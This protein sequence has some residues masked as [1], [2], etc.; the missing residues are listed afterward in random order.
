MTIFILL[1]LVLL[2]YMSVWYFIALFFKRNDVADIAW[3]LGFVLLA[4]ASYYFSYFSIRA[5]I[6]NVLVTIWGGRLAWHIFNRNR[7][8]PEDSRYQAWRES[9]KLFYIRSFLQI[10]LLQGIILFVISYPVMFINL[11]M[12]KA[13]QLTDYLGIAVWLIGFFFESV[14]DRQLKNF[15]SKPENKGK[16]MDQ[17]LWKYTRHPNY[18]GEVT[19]WWGIFLL[20][21]A[22]PFSKFT[23]VGPL[24]I[25]FMILFVSGVP[26]L[27]K[28]YKGRAD[29]VAYK[30]RT[31]IFLPLPPKK[32]K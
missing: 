5:I 12:P 20:A 25:T 22:L 9:W 17:G 13:L 27:E 4:W 31:S 15:I 19:M 16:I 14:G 10:F 18:F 6:V 2:G 23:F 21:L 30:K 1:A 29:F 32:V 3:G 28:K 11:S 24:T 7:K 26:L 8:K